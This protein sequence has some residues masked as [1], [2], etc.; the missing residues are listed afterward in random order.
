[1]KNLKSITLIGALIASCVIV[2]AWA[3]IKS[4]AGEFTIEAQ[5]KF[6]SEVDNL[7]SASQASKSDDA[8][9]YTDFMV[10]QCDGMTGKTMSMHAPNNVVMQLMSFCAGARD[11]QKEAKMQYK[12]NNPLMRGN[13]AY[14]GDFDQAIRAAQSIPNNADYA[15]IY[16]AS[17][18]LIDAAKSIK[19]TTFTFTSPEKSMNL[20]GFKIGPKTVS[21]T[22]H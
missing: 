10:S 4:M 14:C 17:Q 12:Y 13:P 2:P 15:V 16:P 11:L 1:M 19:S 18:K 3:Q 5:N 7:V 20:G 9:S 22:C 6:V 8:Y 21:V